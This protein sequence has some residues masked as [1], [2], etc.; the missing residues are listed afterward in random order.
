[1]SKKP[2]LET[3]TAMPVAVDA[4]PTTASVGA[5]TNQP[6]GRNSSKLLPRRRRSKIEVSN[7]TSRLS[8]RSK[9]AGRLYRR[10]LDRNARIGRRYRVGRIH[11]LHRGSRGRPSPVIRRS[12]IVPTV[13][14]NDA[15]TAERPSDQQALTPPTVSANDVATTGTAD[16]SEVSRQSLTADFSA[17]NAKSVEGTIQKGHVTQHG[18]DELDH[19]E[20]TTWLVED[21]RLGEPKAALWKAD[22]LMQIARHS[23]LRDPKYWKDLPSSYRT[24][25]ELAQIR[26]DERLIELCLERVVHHDITREEA[27]NLR[28]M[29]SDKPPQR[30][31][32]LPLPELREALA[33]LQDI[34][35]IMGGRKVVLAY[36]RGSKPNERR[37]DEDLDQAVGWVKKQRAK[38]KGER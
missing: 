18:K 33:V 30:K 36:I 17:C 5:D 3:T 24:L 16:E 8:R 1:M 26:P 11:R 14:A 35:L 31:A 25:W 23:V 10:C 9:R 37:S 27:E 32:P 20:F 2:K 21:L 38:M 7:G 19:G 15:A 13:P 4:A 29:T 28:R 12:I 6:I 34:I 22:I